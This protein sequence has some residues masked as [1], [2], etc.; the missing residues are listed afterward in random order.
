MLRTASAPGLAIVLLLTASQPLMAQTTAT[1]SGTVRDETGGVLPGA[2]IVVTN[3]ETGVSRTTPADAQGRYRVTNLNIGQYE[4]SASM[5]GFQKAVRQ[6]IAL[7]I[8][9]DAVVDITLKVGDLSEDVTVSGDAPLVD[10]QSGSLGTIVDRDTIL[11]IPL[12]GRDLT[13]LITLQAGTTAATTASKGSNQGFSNKFSIGGARPADN[14]ILLDGTEVKGWDQGVPAGVSGNFLGGEAIQ[15]FKVERNSYSAEYGGNAGGV[16]NVVS[17]SGTN[18]FHGSVYSF[19][20]NDALDATNFRAPAIFDPAGNFVGKDKPDFSRAQFGTSAGGRVIRNR[21]FYFG[22][23]EGMRERLGYTNF[24]TTLTPAGRQ[25][26]LPGRSVQVKTDVVPYLDL[27]PLPG[28]AAIDLGDGTAREPVSQ[29]QPTDEDFFQ[30]RIDHN[31]SDADALF[32]RLTRQRSERTTPEAISRWSG[33]IRMFNTFV[34]AEERKILTPRLLNTFRFGFNRREMI[35]NSTEDPG[36]DPAL[37]IVSP[38]NWRYPL[39]APPILG[40]LSVSPLS[41]VGLGRG[42]AV[43]NTNNIQFVDDVVYTRGAHSLKVGI[44]WLHLRPYGENPSRPG[45]ELTFA[46]IDDFLRGQPRQFRGDILPGTDSIRHLR[47][48]VIGSYVQDDWRVDPR[49]TLNLGFRHEFY[50]VPTERDGKIGNLHDPVNDTQIS[51]GSPWWKNPSLK[52]FAPRVGAS[53]DPTGSGKLAVRGGGGIFYNQ[54]QPEALRQAAWRTAPFGLETNYSAL[55]GQIPFPAGLYDFILGLGEGQADIFVFPFDNAKNP[56]VIQWNLNVQREFMSNTSV[57]VGYAGSRGLDLTSRVAMNTAQAELVNH[58]LVFPAGA[59]RPNRTFNLDLQSLQTNSESWYNAFH[60]ELQRRLRAGW[61][62]QTA[63]TWSKTTDLTSSYNPTFTDDGAGMLYVHDPNLRRGLAAFHVAHRF[64]ASGLWQLPFG[65]GQRFGS[66]W[67]A[68]IDQ[69]LGGWQLSG[70]LT[71]S[72][73]SP[74]SI[75]MARRADLAALGLLGDQPDLVP[76]GDNNPVTG[77]PDR[78]FDTSQFAFPAARTIGNVGRNT[79]IL[80]GIATVDLGLT[81]NVTVGAGSR[82]QIRMEIFNLL[83]R[84]NLGTPDMSVF[85]ARG[86]LQGNAGFIASTSTTARQIQLGG[87]FEW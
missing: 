62:L 35:Q 79:L 52:S 74:A 9:R 26:I 56:R 39:G 82:V 63:Y 81:K 54:L 57:T 14:S 11:E 7:T 58:R 86:N 34:T 40:T 84:A 13:A 48:N 87:R 25:G 42:W 10:T 85:N 72:D 78:Y 60:V 16:V 47:W 38:E 53:W 17:K 12:S 71:L 29:R 61:Q 66:T 19:F 27:W 75:V 50:T 5:S 64:S 43:Y 21:T 31:F 3:S 24:L 23:Y 76:G 30:L 8:G 37:F 67:P 77:D 44:N 18:Q 36:V 4:V 46:S 49:L 15:E 2:E 20:R 70:I 69:A 28:P 45:G 32:G 33:N 59:V 41:G 55:P 22:N 68:W 51:I 1:V 73:G 6:G 65:A 83:N 80:P